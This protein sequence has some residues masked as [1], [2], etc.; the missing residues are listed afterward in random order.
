MCR[1]IELNVFGHTRDEVSIFEKI[2]SSIL[3]QL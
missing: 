1:S 3:S 2:I